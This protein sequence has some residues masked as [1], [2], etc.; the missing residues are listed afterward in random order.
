MDCCSALWVFVVVAGA[1]LTHKSSAKAKDPAVT[2][3]RAKGDTI[4][5]QRAAA[6]RKSGIVR[7]AASSTSSGGGS[8]VGGSAVRGGSAF[9]GLS[10]ILS[11]FTLY[12]YARASGEYKLTHS[13]RRTR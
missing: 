1:C 5:A 7:H 3:H 12:R 4:A 9:G 6:A 10:I 13:S 2:S 8:A 11:A